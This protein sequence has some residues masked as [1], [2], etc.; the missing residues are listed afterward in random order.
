[1]KIMIEMH[2][3]QKGKA[4]KMKRVAYGENGFSLSVAAKGKIN[5]RKKAKGQKFITRSSQISRDDPDL[6]AVIEEMQNEA[7]ANEKELEVAEVPDG[8]DYVIAR[9]TANHEI[10]LCS[11]SKIYDWTDT[12]IL[13]AVQNELIEKDKPVRALRPGE[14]YP[15]TKKRARL[16]LDEMSRNLKLLVK[17][18]LTDVPKGE[19]YLH[20][21]ALSGSE[22]KHYVDRNTFQ[23]VI[24]ECQ[25][26]SDYIVLNWVG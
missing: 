24:A 19:Y 4:I 21:V 16:S 2:E 25:R 20:F 11:K 9:S 5:D 13:E 26:Q 12:E 1:M 23:L 8:Y 18:Q 7:G 22:S 10:V 17:E 3:L 15:T 6:I 14:F